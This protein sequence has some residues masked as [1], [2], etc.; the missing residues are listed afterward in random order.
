[1]ILNTVG[2]YPPQKKVRSSGQN[3]PKNSL[4]VQTETRRTWPSEISKIF[5]RNLWR[6]LNYHPKQCTSKGNF[7]RLPYICTLWSPKMGNWMIPVLQIFHF[8]LY[9]VET[10]IHPKLESIIKN[11]LQSHVAIVWRYFFPLTKHP[12]HPKWWP[13]FI[14]A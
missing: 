9:H 6:S 4:E 13:S 5:W 2:T 3:G 10:W 14:H 7:W 1:M 11:N 12:K 8:I